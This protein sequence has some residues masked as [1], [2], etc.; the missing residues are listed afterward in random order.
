MRRAKGRLARLENKF[1]PA[2]LESLRLI[3]CHV[4]RRANLATSSCTRIVRNGRLT[5]VAHLDG[6]G[7]EYSESE[8]EDFIGSFPIKDNG[9]G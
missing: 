6:S 7:D 3:V 2:Q 1:T 9:W 5:E 8:I 4:G